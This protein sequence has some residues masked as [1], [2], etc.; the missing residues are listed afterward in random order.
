VAHIG[1][2]QIIGSGTPSENS[3]A[4]PSNNPADKALLRIKSLGS[5]GLFIS[6]GSQRRSG[7]VVYSYCCRIFP[8]LAL[9]QGAEPQRKT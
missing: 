8:P 5:E 2:R 1:P 3:L 4:Y 9:R 7:W 6:A